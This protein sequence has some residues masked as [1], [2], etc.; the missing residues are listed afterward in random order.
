MT[1]VQT[2][3]LPILAND[4]DNI[5]RNYVKRG[6]LV[7]WQEIANSYGKAGNE[8]RAFS[9]FASFG[10]PLYKFIGEGSILMHLTNIASGVGKSTALKLVNSV[11]GHPSDTM[12]IEQD[13]NNAKFHR[14]G[15]LNNIPA[16][17]DELTNMAPDK[18]S[19]LDRKSTRLN[20]SHIPLSRMPS[21]A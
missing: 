5:A 3:A 21:S 12:M 16:S 8:P 7:D 20:S 9:L 11:W 10:A 17:F 18:C 2:C 6:S 13:T 4:V 1:G 14:A 15:I 19:D